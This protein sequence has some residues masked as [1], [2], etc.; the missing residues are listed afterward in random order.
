MSDLPNWVGALKISPEE[1]Q[2]WLSEL[3]APDFVLA[4]AIET[5][6]IDEATYLK[7][8]IATY[9]IPLVSPEFL[10]KA[11]PIEMWKKYIYGPWSPTAL[12][13]YEWKDTLVVGVLEPKNFALENVTVQYVMAPLS[14]QQPWW[15]LFAKLKQ[16]CLVGKMQIVV[17]A[18]QVNI[19][20]PTPVQPTLV[21]NVT[22][23]IP[24]VPPA[25]P[26]AP[27]PVVPPPPPVASSKNTE[28]TKSLP[29]L[30]GLKLK[31]KA[32]EPP[33]PDAEPVAAEES[34]NTNGARVLKFP[35]IAMGNVPPA[36]PIGPQAESKAAA[37]ALAPP[38]IPPPIPAPAAETPPQP[39]TEEKK[40]DGEDKKIDLPDAQAM[41]SAI[42][43]LGTTGGLKIKNVG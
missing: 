38:P 26:V 15:R 35:G 40:V 9:Q 37:D 8:A 14:T 1:Y 27:T 7:W 19:V 30:S 34:A 24:V 42:S 31:P 39:S 43:S 33:P 23:A 29:P 3:P 13:L 41:A 16:E 2:R 18:V 36:V 22:H 4:W 20:A 12:P 25:A 32:P 5:G 6:K 21:A 17:P 10:K 28:V 11:A